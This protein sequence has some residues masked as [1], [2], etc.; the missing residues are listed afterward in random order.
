MHASIPPYSL[1]TTFS[2]AVLLPFMP[3][4]MP[5]GGW[6]IEFIA[7]VIGVDRLRFQRYAVDQNLH[8]LTQSRFVTKPE[9]VESIIRSAGQPHNLNYNVEKA[10]DRWFQQPT[11]TTLDPALEKK[12]EASLE[13]LKQ[14]QSHGNEVLVQAMVDLVGIVAAQQQQIA[15]LARRLEASTVAEMQSKIHEQAS[16]HLHRVL[17]SSAK[18]L[19]ELGTPIGSVTAG[20]VTHKGSI[21]LT[22][23]SSSKEQNSSKA[24]DDCQEALQVDIAAEA[25]GLLKSLAGV[26]VSGKV[27]TAQ[28]EKRM[29][30][31]ASQKE[32]STSESFKGELEIQ[33]HGV[34]ITIGK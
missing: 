12:M 30:E 11:T 10:L 24:S 7:Q 29:R 16:D 25:T 31:L 15:E 14:A 23:T 4:P 22:R 27:N 34:S 20:D 1:W 26:A 28:V 9:D 6:P 21:T 18:A 32:T 5:P 13:A 33:Y 2:Q 3:P 17:L 8:K 19:K